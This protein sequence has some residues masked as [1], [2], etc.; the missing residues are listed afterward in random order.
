MYP[1]RLASAFQPRRRGDK[2]NLAENRI[3]ATEESDQLVDSETFEDRDELLHGHQ[4]EAEVWWATLVIMHG[5]GTYDS[6]TWNCE[7]NFD[8]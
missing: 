4:L 7:I 8:T 5:V 3:R 1:R 6:K 2:T